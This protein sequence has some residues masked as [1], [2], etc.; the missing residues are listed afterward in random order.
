MKRIPL[1][2][3]VLPLVLLTVATGCKNRKNRDNTLR[4]R[5]LSKE[6]ILSKQ[7]AAKV[8]FNFM[9]FKGKAEF[10]TQREGKKQGMSFSYKAY[11]AKD[12]LLW[13][14]VSKFGIPAANVLIDR[15][16]V[17]MR[18]SLERM[19]ILCDFSVLSNMTGMDRD[20]GLVQSFFTGDPTLNPSALTLIPNETDEFI[21][22]ENRP[23]YQVSWFLNG[24][25][26]KLD[27]MVAE[28]VN[29]GRKS[30]VTYSDFKD[31]SGE[32]VPGRALIETTQGSETRI[33]LQ[34]STIEIEPNKTNFKFRIPDSYEIRDC[35]MQ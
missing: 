8:D 6:D 18:V 34:H 11:L 26:Y 5:G 31:V 29:L 33:E 16:S 21:L 3:L 32:K 4:V 35:S 14:S 27:K 9:Y 2:F 24:K 1:L 20:F 10:E 30:T 28:D 7:H 22:R 17:K 12:S 13:A 15:D 19:A 25:H 23:P